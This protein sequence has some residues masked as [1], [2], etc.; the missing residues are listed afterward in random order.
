MTILFA[1]FALIWASLYAWGYHVNTYTTRLINATM[2]RVYRIPLAQARKIKRYI[3]WPLA[4]SSR[5]LT[6]VVWP[7]VGV[8]WLWLTKQKRREVLANTITRV[9]IP[10]LIGHSALPEAEVR[11]VGHVL[12]RWLVYCALADEWRESQDSP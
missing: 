8:M 9:I 10:S 5:I 12:G 7:F 1:I 3:P 6:I 2:A 4:W 11:K